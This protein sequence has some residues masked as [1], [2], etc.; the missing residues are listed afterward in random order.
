MAP[1][2]ALL[3]LHKKK[4]VDSTRKYVAEVQ[5]KAPPWTSDDKMNLNKQ[6]EM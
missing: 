2:L 4:E 6:F 5:H 1:P 3:V